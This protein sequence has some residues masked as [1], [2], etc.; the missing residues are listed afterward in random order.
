[1]K[2]I[3]LTTAVMTLSAGALALAAAPTSPL[4]IVDRIAGPDGGWDYANFDPVHRRLYI[5]HGAA[6]TA[7]DVDSRQVTP[8]LVATQRAHIALPLPGGDELLVTNGGSDTAMLVDARSGAIRAAIPTGQNPDAALFDPASGLAFVMNGRSGDITLIDIKAAKAVGTIAVGGKLE[9]GV[10]DGRGR[11]FVNVEDKGE[12]AVIDTAAR[13]VVAHWRMAGCEEPSGLAYAADAKLLIAACANGKAEVVSSTSGKVVGRLAIG[14]EP[15]A[16]FYDPRRHLVYI[17]SGG[18]GTLSVIAVR[19]PKD[20]AVIERLET[21][22]G[23][24]TGALDPLAG[25]VYLPSADYDPPALP[26][27]RRSPKIGSFAVLV[28]GH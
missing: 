19:G 14:E 26:A 13:E 2:K 17:P 16:A 7:V 9:F 15:D 12:I 1:M 24:R 27:G 3:L 5:A 6:I 21:K 4:K 11:V 10:A 22:V 28:V 18:D 25:K 8:V 23:A 20:V